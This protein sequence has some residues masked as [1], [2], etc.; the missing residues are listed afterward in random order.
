MARLGRG[1]RAWTSVVGAVVLLALG[2]AALAPSDSLAAG[3][4]TAASEAPAVTAA[5]DDSTEPPAT[6]REGFELTDERVA[7]ANEADAACVT[8][9]A[10]EWLDADAA[11][12]ADASDAADA[13]VLVCLFDVHADRGVS[14]VDCHTDAAKLDDVHA[15]AD[16][17]KAPSRLRA[18][19]VTDEA[20]LACHIDRAALAEAL[21]DAAIVDGKGTA[22]NPHALPDFSD[23]QKITCVQCHE[24]HGQ[25]DLA[26]DAKSTCL[27]CHHADVF[28]CGTC[29]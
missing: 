4:A 6:L 25:T 18:T 12:A 7:R 1:V 11:G 10:M 27:T 19:K 20:C 13:P 15:K 26:Q 17:K 5:D 3:Q 9:H 2:T 14:C 16:G 21:P 24:V 23:H 22:A 28:E 29:H 8:C